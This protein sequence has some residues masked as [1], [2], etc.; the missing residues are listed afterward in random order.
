MKSNNELIEKRR[1][2]IRRKK[3][4]FFIVILITTLVTLCLKLHYFN[5]KNIIVSNNKI[6]KSSQIINEASVP[7]NTNI[8]YLNIGKVQADI[9]DNPYVKDVKITRSLPSTLVIEV[10]ER[11]AAFYAEKDKKFIIIDKE[12][13]VLEQRDD[14]TNLKLVKLEGVNTNNAQVG[15]VICAS[16]SAKLDE[17]NKITEII[18]NNS[19]CKSITKVNIN[20]STDIQLFYND[21]CIKLGTID[22]M[23]NKLNE[24]I[25]II[26]KQNL[27][28]SKGYVDVSFNGNPVYFVQK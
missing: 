22:D 21:M 2:K 12:G 8:F 16:D 27:S 24:A 18:L 17:I 28:N 3:T 4:F 1:K 10:T 5:V 11:S 20:D 7:N 25:N 14:L 9:K 13:L 6:L 15:K 26:T 19:S 23:T